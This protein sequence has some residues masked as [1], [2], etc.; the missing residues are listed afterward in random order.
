MVPQNDDA[1]NDDDIHIVL[2][3]MTW[4]CA[5]HMQQLWIS[6]LFPLLFV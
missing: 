6:L 1:D 3:M 4:F 2:Y 5:A